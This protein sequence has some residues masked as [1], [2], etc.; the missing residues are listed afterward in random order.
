MLR[1]WKKNVCNEISCGQF[2][3]ISTSQDFAMPGFLVIIPIALRSAPSGG[4]TPPSRALF[5][6]TVV[7]LWKQDNFYIFSCIKEAV[8]CT[9]IALTKHN[10]LSLING[11]QI[12]TTE[13]DLTIFNRF[14]MFACK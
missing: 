6:M 12:W 4:A 3:C 13:V 10:S 11:N 9:D 2:R 1:L 5:R 7:I 14:I 8:R